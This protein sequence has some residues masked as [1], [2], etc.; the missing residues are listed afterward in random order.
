[1]E[2]NV[3]DNLAYFS[4]VG[5]S[6][7]GVG[8]SSDSYTSDIEG[9]ISFALILGEKLILSCHQMHSNILFPLQNRQ[10]IDITLLSSLVCRMQDP[11]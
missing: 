3:A 6:T 7:W 9:I 4:L 5:Q 11:D 1:M 2:D 10:W 8:V